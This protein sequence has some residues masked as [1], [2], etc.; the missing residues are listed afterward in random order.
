VIIGAHQDSV[1]LWLPSFGTAP[2]ADVSK[3][4]KLVMCSDG[5]ENLTCLLGG[6]N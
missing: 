2:G 6:T 5:T 1:N 3:M 4:G